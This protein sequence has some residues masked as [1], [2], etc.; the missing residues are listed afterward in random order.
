VGPDTTVSRV[1]G[2]LSLPV[3]ADTRQRL[4]RGEGPQADPLTERPVPIPNSRATSA[5]V[6]SPRTETNQSPEP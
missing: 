5:I 6:G 4:G 2:S 1:E 3:R